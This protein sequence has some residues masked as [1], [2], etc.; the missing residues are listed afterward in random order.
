MTALATGLSLL[1]ISFLWAALPAI[2]PQ[3]TAVQGD[4]LAAAEPPTSEPPPARPGL[5]ASAFNVSL[6]NVPTIAESTP[7]K[8]EPPLPASNLELIA[9]ICE[10]GRYLAALYEIDADRLHIVGSGERIGR[11]EVAE[12]DSR[13]VNLRDGSKRFRL[14]ISPQPALPQSRLTVLNMEDGKQ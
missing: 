10:S 4:G 1:V 7:A 5:D 14:T 8:E 9:I 6:W 12:V 2:G 3:L 11:L 13:S